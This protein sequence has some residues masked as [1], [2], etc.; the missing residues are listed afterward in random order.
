M[1]VVVV[2]V[3]VVTPLVVVCVVVTPARMLGGGVDVE[4][5]TTGSTAKVV[6]VVDGPP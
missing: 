2:T 5:T 3:T 6:Y 4:M 1:I